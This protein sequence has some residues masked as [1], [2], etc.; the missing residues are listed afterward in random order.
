M[1]DRIIAY[2]SAELVLESKQG[3]PCLIGNT[4]VGKT[5]MVK[6]LAKTHNKNLIIINTSVMNADD[7]AGYPYIDKKTGKMTWAIPDWFPTKPGYMIFLDEF[8]RA[9]KQVIN[10]LMPLLLSGELHHG[11][12]LPE[13]CWLAVAF[14]PDTDDYDM[15]NSFDDL[16]ISSRLIKIIVNNDSMAWAEWARNSLNSDNY[17]EYVSELIDKMEEYIDKNDVLLDIE[18]IPNNRSFTKAIGIIRFVVDN[19]KLEYYNVDVVL[20]TLKGLLGVK[21]V[22]ENK[23]FLIN[24][25]TSFGKSVYEQIKEFIDSDYYSDIHEKLYALDDLVTNSQAN[26]KFT[27]KDLE[28][29]RDDILSNEHLAKYNRVILTALKTTSTTN[30]SDKYFKD[31]ITN[32]DFDELWNLN[33]DY[34]LY[35]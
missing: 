24:I 8:N 3:V 32:N 25:L 20:N 27:E 15:V 28:L 23:Q 22:N 29:L 4:G 7:L 12:K 35:S 26:N 1:F 17:Q 11:A 2:R 33:S 30:D 5:D 13:D 19:G 16:A 9:D 18:Q 21:Y 10:A 34:N 6:E 14:N 31:I